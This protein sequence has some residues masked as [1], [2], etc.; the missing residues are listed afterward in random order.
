MTG[1]EDLLCTLVAPHRPATRDAARGRAAAQPGQRR[2]LAQAAPLPGRRA[3]G[4]GERG[5][6]ARARGE[7]RAGGEVVARLDARRLRDPGGVEKRTRLGQLA[8]LRRLS[9][10][11]QR[12]LGGAELHRG[13][14]D[15][16]VQCQAERRRLGQEQRVV[17]LA[18]VLD[19]RDVR[20]RDR[21]RAAAGCLGPAPPAARAHPLCASGPNRAAKHCTPRARAFC[22][23]TRACA[24]SCATATAAPPPPAPASLAPKAPSRP[25]AAHTATSSVQETPSAARM[26]WAASK[27]TPRSARS[28]RTSASAPPRAS[29][30][31]AESSGS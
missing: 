27:R 10:E 14:G 21:C 28:P 15:E 22:S 4:D 12:I 31:S 24:A 7:A 20:V 5:E 13:G 1:R 18:P 19:Q 25:T 2:Q 23:S 29:S 17:A 3:G 6:A 11:E 26:P 30:P 16:L 9:V 8:G